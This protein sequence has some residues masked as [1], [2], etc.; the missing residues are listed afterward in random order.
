MM[1]L[2]W[3][4]SRAGEEKKGLEMR[5]PARFPQRSAWGSR[6]Q[7]GDPDSLAVCIQATCGPRAERKSKWLFLKLRRA[8]P[9]IPFPG[10]SLQRCV[11]P[12]HHPLEQ[13]AS[14]SSRRHNSIREAFLRHLL[15]CFSNST[16]LNLKYSALISNLTFYFD[17]CMSYFNFI[18]M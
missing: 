10:D 5:Y 12:W 7:P 13:E 9:V 14:W 8:T 2:V 17:I 11:F 6:F 4:A 15:A 16:V 18:L 1:I 3:S